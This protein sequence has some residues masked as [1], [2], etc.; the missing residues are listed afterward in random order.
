MDSPEVVEVPEGRL[1]LKILVML[2]L[3]R[4]PVVAVL[5]ELLLEVGHQ[6]QVMAAL[7]V[8]TNNLQMLDFLLVGLQV[9]E[10]V[11][12][13]QTVH[14]LK[15]IFQVLPLVQKA[16]A[17]V[18]ET[19]LLLMLLWVLQIPVGV[20]VVALGIILRLMHPT[21]VQVLLFLDI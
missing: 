15:L 9:A 6:Q 5:A 19:V 14:L 2:F 13:I 8:I 3:M 1:Q 4:V 12:I 18:E 7:D 11:D 20:V 17:G 16:G 10:A 21:V